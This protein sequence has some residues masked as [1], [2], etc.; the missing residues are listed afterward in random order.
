VLFAPHDDKHADAVER[1]L[2]RRSVAA[3][4]LDLS[5]VTGRVSI[6]PGEHVIVGEVLIEAGVSVWWRRIGIVPPLAELSAEENRLR[7]EE[8]EALLVGGLLAL[9]HRWVDEPF[10]VEAAEHSLKQLA[11]AA[12]LG[13]AIPRSVATND[14]VTAHAA[15]GAG[16]QW[17]AKATSAGVGIAPYA[18][19]VDPGLFELL[20]RCITLLQEV[21]GASADVR[22]VVVGDRSW[23]WMR[24]RRARDPLDWR[25]ADPAGSEF[26]IVD[27]VDVATRAVAINVSLSLRFSVQ[28][29]VVVDDEPVFLE[30]NPSGQWLF[31][32][33]AESLIGDA[34][35]SLLT[36]DW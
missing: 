21:Q 22:V 8:C 4:R 17:L 12:R 9:T 16:S 25:A 31:L 14:P 23:T 3:S 13:I 35:A 19:L 36:E 34:L 27:R 11:V 24:P 29:W 6:V 7:A 15:Y 28:D 2:D 26:A 30:V 1:A 18:D 32:T 20:P 33:G 5:A 10:L